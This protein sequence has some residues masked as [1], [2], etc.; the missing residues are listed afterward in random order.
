MLNKKLN[1][2]SEVGKSRIQIM[3]EAAPT[4]WFVVYAAFAAF[5]TYF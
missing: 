5:A 1:T 3:L 4:R 2:I